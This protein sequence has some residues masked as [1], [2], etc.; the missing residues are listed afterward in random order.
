MVVSLIWCG[1]SSYTTTTYIGTPEIQ[2]NNFIS[3]FAILIPFMSLQWHTSCETKRNKANFKI[4]ILARLHLYTVLARNHYTYTNSIGGGSSMFGYQVLM[5]RIRSVQVRKLRLFN[6][7]SFRISS[8]W[9][10][11]SIKLQTDTKYIYRW[12]SARYIWIYGI[13]AWV[14]PCTIWKAIYE[15]FIVSFVGEKTNEKNNNQSILVAEILLCSWRTV[16][17]LACQ[18]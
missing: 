7:F 5:F 8:C 12:A 15:E 2:Q 13:Y 6:H 1:E 9:I 17:D 18:H 3:Q 14:D 16:V 4:K 11:L 10:V